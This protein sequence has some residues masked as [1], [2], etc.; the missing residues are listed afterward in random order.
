LQVVSDHINALQAQLAQREGVIKA[1]NYDY[2]RAISELKAAEQAAATARKDAL[3]EAANKVMRHPQRFALQTEEAVRNGLADA[4]LALLDHPAPAPTPEAAARVAL[5]W[6]AK[7]GDECQAKNAR[8][9]WKDSE[10]RAYYKG[11][12]AGGQAIAAAIRALIDHPT[13]IAAIISSA[14]DE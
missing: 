5:E 10:N 3:R 7:M 11:L 14:G 9:S 8:K 1:Q 12:E 13:T 4:I 2:E 6:A